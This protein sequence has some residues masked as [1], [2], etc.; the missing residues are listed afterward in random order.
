[1]GH[2][3]YVRGRV[4]GSGLLCVEEGGRGMIVVCRRGR[5]GRVY[6]VWE[7]LVGP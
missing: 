6:C 7:R 3:C 1:M 5:V 2:E 4:G